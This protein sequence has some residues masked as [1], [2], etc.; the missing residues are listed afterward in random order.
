MNLLEKL[1]TYSARIPDNMF[2]IANDDLG[3]LILVVK[4][5]E[6]GKV[7]FWD[8][9]MEVAE[10]EIPDYSNLTLISDSFDDFINSLR[11]TN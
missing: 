6:R 3:N 5:P 2:P 10:G 8:H 7:Y 9:E 4:R 1:K 11:T